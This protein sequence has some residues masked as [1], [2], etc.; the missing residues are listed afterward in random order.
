MY[1]ELA[2]Q[3]Q[4]VIED[5]YPKLFNYYAPM[6]GNF[7][8]SKQGVAIHI[9]DITRWLEE[10]DDYILMFQEDTFYLTDVKE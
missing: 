7:A 4:K 5:S 6:M 10:F 3:Q 1:T 8:F 9:D 2:K